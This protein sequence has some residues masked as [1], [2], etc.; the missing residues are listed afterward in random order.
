MICSAF[1]G[2]RVLVVLG[3]GLG[4]SSDPRHIGHEFFVRSDDR[5]QE[6]W[7]AWPHGVS[8]VFLSPLFSVSRQTQHV[9][10]WSSGSVVD[11]V[12]V[13]SA[14]AAAACSH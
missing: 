7:Y 1:E 10:V 3:L 5:R 6:R 12:V 13:V 4:S 9:N 2:R 8:V 11:M 14:A